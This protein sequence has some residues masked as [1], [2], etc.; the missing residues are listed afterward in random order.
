MFNPIKAIIPTNGL[1]FGMKPAMEFNIELQMWEDVVG[2]NLNYIL[3]NGT[4]PFSC[5]IEQNTIKPILKLILDKPITS[6]SLGQEYFITINGSQNILTIV[7]VYEDTYRN[8]DW[9]MSDPED[10]AGNSFVF[11]EVQHGTQIVSKIF[12]TK[13]KMLFEFLASLSF[14]FQDF[15]GSLETKKRI[16][17]IVDSATFGMGF[18]KNCIASVVRETDGRLSTVDLRYSEGDEKFTRITYVYENGTI[19]Y[20]FTDPNLSSPDVI[21]PFLSQILIDR[22]SSAN[23]GA[24]RRYKICTIQFA[25]TPTAYTTLFGCTVT[26]PAISGWEV[27]E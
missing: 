1:S 12:N 18:P 2:S 17:D 8:S 22:I 11:K 26:I 14:R 27:L 7:F 24:A 19:S 3:N 9:R 16:R 25:R 6:V 5:S 15:L 10:I 21:K 13:L 20:D 23:V 4:N